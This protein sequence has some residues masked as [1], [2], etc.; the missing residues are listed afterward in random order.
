MARGSN[1]NTL[2]LVVVGLLLAL[3]A[4][5]SMRGTKDTFENSNKES[6]PSDTSQDIEFVGPADSP[7]PASGM[8]PS[9]GENMPQVDFQL[10]DVPDEEP[11]HQIGF[12][13]GPGVLGS[14]RHT[15]E[16]FS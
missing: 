2:I 8:R 16:M 10:M 3:A 9:A 15:S 4:W 5:Y 13:M 14:G 7:P 1:N 11:A 12:G 6:S